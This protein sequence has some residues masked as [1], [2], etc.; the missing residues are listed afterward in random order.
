MSD[1]TERAVPKLVDF[2]LAK[3]LG[4]NE[5]TNETFGTIGYCAPEVLKKDYY[6]YSCDL[7]SLGCLIYAMFCG[8]LPFDDKLTNNIAK[9]TIENDL[10]FKE[11]VWINVS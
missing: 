4:P 3:I 1:N 11:K 10:V 8:Y 9:M 6:S 5:L 7:W 2:G